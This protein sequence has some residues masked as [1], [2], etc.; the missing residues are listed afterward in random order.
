MS[1]KQQTTEVVITLGWRAGLVLLAVL[2]ASTALVM[3]IWLGRQAALRTQSG[4]QGFAALPQSGP[5]AVPVPQAP[6]VQTGPLVQPR[7]ELPSGLQPYG[8]QLSQPAPEFELE[9]LDGE[10]V[11]LSDFQGQPVLINFWATWC[12]PCRR[13]MPM[14]E[15]AWRRYKDQG[16]VILGVNTGE[17]VR[18]GRLREEV[19]FYVD[20]MGLT[21]P[22]LLDAEEVVANLYNLRS[23]PTSF[24]VNRD[25]VLVDVRR[26]AFASPAELDRY[27]S[28]IL[29][30]AGGD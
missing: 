15:G 10:L 27:I 20:Q 9:N 7:T 19:G 2:L 26:G 18:A 13:E 8:L 16:F 3:G 1:D 22:I 17:R 21:F 24:F 28:R 12:P 30:P 29:T 14:L 6:V 4:T 11:H 23:Y 5:Q 25:G